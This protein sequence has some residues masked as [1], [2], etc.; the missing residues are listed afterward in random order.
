[1]GSIEENV[2]EW[3]GL[4]SLEPKGKKGKKDNGEKVAIAEAVAFMEKGVMGEAQLALG[5]LAVSYEAKQL[6]E[7]G[8]TLD[9]L[10]LLI[11]SRLPNMSN[12]NKPSFKL[13]ASVLKAVS[14][15]DQFVDKAALVKVREARAKVK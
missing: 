5:L 4:S 2:D 12:G 14:E 6:L 10:T 1:M 13:I 11:Q 8:L 3:I 15:L 9:A 7:G